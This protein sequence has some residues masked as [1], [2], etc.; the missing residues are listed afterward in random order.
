MLNGDA[1]SYDVHDGDGPYLL[2]VHGFLSGRS[3]WLPN[4]KALAEVSR[5]VVVELFGHGRSPSPEDPAAYTPQAYVAAFETIRLRLGA[6]RWFLCGQSLGAALTLR[7]AL[8]HPDRVLAQVFTNSN[9]ALAEAGWAERIRPGLEAQARRLIDDG[10]EAIDGHA[11]NPARSKRLE[12]EVRKKLT[13]D[14]AMHDPRGLAWSGLYTV[15][16]SSVRDRIRENVVPT[17]MVVGE[18]EERFAAHRHAA[19][20]AMPHLET[21]AL[22]G[23]H[24]V[25]LDATEAFNREVV[26]FFRRHVLTS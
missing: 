1:I 12:P 25:N 23:G 9:S 16:T 2:L 20:E 19:D 22:D 8:D 3:Q 24:A 18:R 10:R 21:V 26:E 11:L 14:V 5:P 4:L 6:E 13:E 7:Y 15:P 17:L